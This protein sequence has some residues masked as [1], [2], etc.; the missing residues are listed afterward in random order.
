MGRSTSGQGRPASTAS[1][2]DAHLGRLVTNASPC[3]PV[4]VPMLMLVRD[5]ALAKKLPEAQGGILAPGKGWLPNLPRPQDLAGWHRLS[6]RSVPAQVWALA[7]SWAELCA[8]R[9]EILKAEPPL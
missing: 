4:P 3:Q 7:A 8:F 5:P 9:L 2:Q 6:L 1:P